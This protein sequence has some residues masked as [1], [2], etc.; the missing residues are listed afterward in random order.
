MAKRM[1]VP[2]SLVPCS[3]LFL[4]LALTT[5]PGRAQS[6]RV[7]P[8]GEKPDDVRLGDLKNLNGY[9]PF[10]P[11]KTAELWQARSGFL[12]LQLNVAC[13]LH[14]MPGKT[15]ANAVVHGL[16]DRG[17]YTVERV[18]LQSFP[19]HFVTGSLYRPKGKSGILPGVLCPHGHWAD[20]RF[21][22]APEAEFKKQLEV[23]AEKF[24][25][26]GRYPL[27]A[28]C[29]QLARMGCVVFHYDMVGYADSRQLAHRPGLREAMNTA[30]NWGYFSPQAELRLQNMMGLQTYNSIRALDW[31]ETLPDVD[32]QRIAVTGAS[33]GGTQT[34]ILCAVDKRPAVAFPAVMVSTAMQGG[35][36][37]ENA[38]YLRVTEGNIGIAGLIAPRPLGMTAADDWTVEIATK[39]LPELKALYALLGHPDRVEATPLTQFPHNYNYPSRA[40]MYRWLN[41]HL[42]LGLSEDQLTERDFDPLTRE[43]LTVWDGDHPQPEGGDD[44]ERGLLKWITSDWEKQIGSAVDTV[45]QAGGPFEQIVGGGVAAMFGRGVVRWKAP[46]SEEERPI[47][48]CADFQS[49]ND[50]ATLAQKDTRRDSY[51]ESTLLIASES[52]SEQVPAIL[53]RPDQWNRQV[54]VW[55][56][57]HGK[58]GAYDAEGKPIASVRKLLNAGVAVL[59]ID[60]FGQG[61]FTDDGN[62]I[63]NARINESGRGEWA[64]YAGYTFGYNY[65][66]FTK[67]VHDILTAVAWCHTDAIAAQRVHLVGLAGAGRWVAAARA[68][69]YRTVDRAVVDTGGFRFAS[70][71]RFDHP[72]FLPGGAKYLD[73]PG[74]LALNARDP[75]WLAGEGEQAPAIVAAAYEAAKNSQKLIVF[76]GKQ[77]EQSAAAVDW[78]LRE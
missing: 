48:L 26:S 54:A 18:Y 56:S 17:E 37:C 77:E 35:C 75:L 78:L 73:L 21:Y 59:A 74:M 45:G 41:Q 8:P 23:G 19:G 7:L 4:A 64:K 13:G 58:V 50:V 36:T 67:R 47:Y 9:F 62:P 11:P 42:K 76:D 25:P 29:V 15:P 14:P 30:E 63:E 1:N 6:P 27:Q 12:R 55:V 2:Q 3:A 72:D 61:E 43:Q 5:V 34:F 60:L 71:D 57:P 69:C 68:L 53:L 52:L 51:V 33:G 10:A 16:V 39:G 28:R 44:Y 31:F 24:D 20:G 66:V 65:P 22:E 70:I 46:D 49:G 32:P 38:C 40:A